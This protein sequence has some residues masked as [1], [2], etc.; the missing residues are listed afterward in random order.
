[1]HGVAFSKID[2]PQKIFL[3]DSLVTFVH[4]VCAY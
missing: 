3:I 1:M 4:K 2:F